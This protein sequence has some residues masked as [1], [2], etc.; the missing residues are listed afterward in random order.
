MARV[1]I[2]YGRKIMIKPVLLF[3]GLSV[4]VLLQILARVDLDDLPALAQS[5]KCLRAAVVAYVRTQISDVSCGLE[6]LKIPCISAR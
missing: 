1:K 6:S 3:K 4:D 5:C 2:A